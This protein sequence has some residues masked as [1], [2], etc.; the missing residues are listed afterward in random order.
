ML[1]QRILRYGLGLV[2]TFLFILHASNNFPIPILHTLE[3][4]T[5]DFRL[6]MTLPK[7]VEKKVV[8]IDIDEKSLSEIGQ[9]PWDRNILAQIVDNLFDRYNISVLGFDILF[10]EKDEDPSD[11]YLLQ[12]ANSE[13]AQQ[14]QFQAIYNHAAK[15]LNRDQRLAN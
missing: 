12:L 3:N 5:Y 10:A 2:F 6:R 9:W 15:T 14:P 1:K 7:N 13:L 11:Q 8:I 4:L